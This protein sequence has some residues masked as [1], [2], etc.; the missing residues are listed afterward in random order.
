MP[1]PDADDLLR[2]AVSELAAR[3]D[4]SWAGVFFVEGDELLLGPH[5]GMPEPERRVL[6]P[7]EWRGTRVAEL[8][9]DGTPDRAE[10]EALAVTLADVCLVAWDTGGEAWES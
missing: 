5:A 2:R 7:V 3:N 9:V 8:A 4:C 1:G 10:L 6:V